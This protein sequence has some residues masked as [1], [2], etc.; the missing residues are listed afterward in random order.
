MS[1]VMGSIP[2]GAHSVSGTTNTEGGRI[3]IFHHGGSLMSLSIQDESWKKLS[4]WTHACAYGKDTV[5]VLAK[6]F[7]FLQTQNEKESLEN[8]SF[9]DD[10]ATVESTYY[11][12]IN[13]L[14]SVN[15]EYQEI[16]LSEI[17]NSLNDDKNQKGVHY[18]FSTNELRE[19]H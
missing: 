6:K 3:R 1:E 12:F 19:E 7:N 2:I 16:A 18:L 10:L 15:I 14:N 17:L 9:G 13:S 8:L 5:K 11:Y 4:N